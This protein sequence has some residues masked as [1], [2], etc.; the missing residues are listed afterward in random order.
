[1]HVWEQL[2]TIRGSHLFD[3]LEWIKHSVIQFLWESCCPD[4]FRREFDRIID[5]IFHLF[6]MFVGLLSHCR[7]DFFHVLLIEFQQLLHSIDDVINLSCFN[8]FTSWVIIRSIRAETHSWMK[9]FIHV[10]EKH[11]DERK[12]VVVV[13]ELR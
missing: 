3:Y 11:W 1:M 7:S 2:Q 12:Y 9:A 6:A 4:V 10:K 13:T 8:S 5:L